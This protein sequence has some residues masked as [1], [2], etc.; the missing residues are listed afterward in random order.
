MDDREIAADF[1]AEARDIF[2][3]RIQISAAAKPAVHST[4]TGGSIP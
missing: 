2:L 1:S 4:G 3:R